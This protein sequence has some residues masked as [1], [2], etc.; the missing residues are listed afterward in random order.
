MEPRLQQQHWH[1][2]VVSE[3]K[4]EGKLWVSVMETF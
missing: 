4:E 3:E 2:K 1:H